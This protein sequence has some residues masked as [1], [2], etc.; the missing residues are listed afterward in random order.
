MAARTGYFV[1]LDQASMAKAKAAMTGIPKGLERAVTSAIN[2][3]LRKIQVTSSRE[4]REEYAISS[5]EAKQT[6]SYKKANFS[7]LMGYMNSVSSRF[8]LSRFATGSLENKISDGHKKKNVRLRIKKN[9]PTTLTHSNPNYEGTPFVQ[10]MK[11][12][13]IGIYQ[14]RRGSRGIAELRTIT[15]PQMLQADNVSEDVLKEGE[16]ILG[17]EFERNVKRII[18]GFY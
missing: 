10:R 2:T 6:L 15:V 12:G 5:K 9:A 1:T 18:A 11:T 13:H 17:T 14:R 16:T 4:M 3:T 8:S 7:S